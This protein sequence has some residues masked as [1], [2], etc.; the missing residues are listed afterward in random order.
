MFD[1]SNRLTI[2]QSAR[3]IGVV[4]KTIIRWENSGKVRKAKRDWRNWRVYSS[5]DIDDLKK[6]KFSEY[7]VED[8]KMEDFK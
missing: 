2:T 7:S 8:I 4:P 3:I 1:E 6:F 5:K